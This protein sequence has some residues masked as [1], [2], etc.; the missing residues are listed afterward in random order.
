[1]DKSVGWWIADWVL[2]GEAR[3]GERF[4][5]AVSET[6]L[7]EQTIANRLSVARGF[8]IF[9]RRGGVSFSHHAALTALPAAEQDRLLDL[10]EKEA[11]SVTALRRAAAGARPH[12]SVRGFA[13]STNDEGPMDAPAAPPHLEVGSLVDL[14]EQ[15][16]CRV[17]Y[18]GHGKASILVNCVRVPTEET[19]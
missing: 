6:G 1:M 10:A 5:Q 9:R 13:S 18:I 3:Y 15:G 16:C 12:P 19:P 7:A 8:P 17:T 14:G 2:A 4:A 11:L